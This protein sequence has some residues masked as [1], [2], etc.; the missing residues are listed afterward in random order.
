[1]E[2]VQGSRESALREP[3]IFQRARWKLGHGPQN[4]EFDDDHERRN[5]GSILFKMDNRAV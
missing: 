2:M 3:T 4:V 5:G 1:M